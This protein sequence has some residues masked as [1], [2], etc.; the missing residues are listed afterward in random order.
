MERVI[1]SCLVYGLSDMFGNVKHDNNGQVNYS[2]SCRE[3][4]RHV[5][6]NHQLLPLIT[7]ALQKLFNNATIY[8]SSAFHKHSGDLLFP[9]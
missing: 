4:Q 6:C 1:I 3:P 8:Y 7:G 9:A 2:D 5:P